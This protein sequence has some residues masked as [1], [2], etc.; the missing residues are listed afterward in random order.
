[1]DRFGGAEVY[2]GG[3]DRLHHAGSRPAAAPRCDRW[4][5]SSRRSRRRR[6]SRTGACCTRASGATAPSFEAADAVPAGRA[7]RDRTARRAPSGPWSAAASFAESNFNRA[8]QAQRQP[9]SA[10]KPIVAAQAIRQGYTPNSIL[11]DTPLSYHWG[12]QTWSPQNFDH[13]FRGPV[14]LRYTL[15]KSI[16][17]PTI[18]LLEAVGPKNVVEMAERIGFTGHIT[19]QLSLALGTAEVTP[20]EITSAYASFANRGIRV[21]PYSIER[22]EDR[23]GRFLL[24][25]RPVSHEVLDERSSYFMISLLRSVIDH[26]TGYPARGQYGFD[27]P[28]A[29][30]TGT[31]DDYSDA[32][33]VGF[34]PRLACGVW[35]GFDV[36]K[37]IGSRMTG[38]AAALPAW[39]GF[40]NEAVKVYGKEDFPP[41]DGLVVV[42]TCA[43]SGLL[44]TPGC[45]RTISDV[46][47]PGTQPTQYCTIH[48]GLAP[49]P[50]QTAPSE[51]EAP[52]PNE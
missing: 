44:A 34:V 26:G 47:M 46:Y 22:V 16:N 15:Q 2:E 35:V 14:T 21:E 40:M 20:L 49:V 1:M 45:P 29:G 12:G 9:G 7:R 18:R 37:S 52:D 51:D 42:T 17:V 23:S 32:W 50:D 24:E 11:Q 8:V 27:A 19:P 41:P 3:L 31:T 48:S 4:R 5:R 25:H 28:A 43:V 36:R 6:A 10:F 38:A 30:K 33:F 39:C 13:K